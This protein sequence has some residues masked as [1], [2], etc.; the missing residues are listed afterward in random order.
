MALEVGER[1]CWGHRGRW[2]GARYLKQCCGSSQRRGPGSWLDV[3]VPMGLSVAAK[4]RAVGSEEEKGHVSLLG[5]W[6]SLARFVQGSTD[7]LTPCLGNAH[8][9]KVR[10]KLLSWEKKK[11]GTGTTILYE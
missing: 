8:K 10:L 6:F 5:G 9:C 4:Q 7:E 1:G 3:I 2:P 11:E